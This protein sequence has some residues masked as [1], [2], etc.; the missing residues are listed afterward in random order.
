MK[1]AISN[2]AWPL[3]EEQAVATLLNAMGITGVEI[4]PTKIW[5][6]PLLATAD[7]IARYR[8]FWAAQGIQIVAIQSLL[9]GCPDLT[10]FDSAAMRQE[11]LAYLQQI[12]RLSAQ[13]GA[14]ALVFGSPKNRL[15]KDLP[16]DTIATIALDFFHTAGEMAAAYGVIFCLEPNPTHYGCD[17]ITTSAEGLALVRQVNSPGFGLHL[18]AAGMTM[19]EEPLA[20]AMAQCAGAIEHFHASEPQL[21]ALGQGG[22]DHSTLA[23]LLRQIRY[24]HWVSVEMRHDSSVDTQQELPRVLTYLQATYGA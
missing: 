18:D 5:P 22:V 8:R 2:L 23:A 21:G 10:I 17:F 19:S 3:A 16:A 9:F 14:R 11:T 20:Q 6:K 7:E 24:P 12:M 1:L 15:V 13:L 4:A